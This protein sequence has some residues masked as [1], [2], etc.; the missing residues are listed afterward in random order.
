M[1]FDR[2]CSAYY[3]WLLL[4]ESYHRGA[5]L[6]AAT[7][8]QSGTTGAAARGSIDPARRGTGIAAANQPS[9]VPIGAG[10]HTAAILDTGPARQPGGREPGA[11][12]AAA[13]PDTGRQVA[14]H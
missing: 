14:C 2:V 11:G 1:P 12:C 6:G 9:A 10:A 4:R 8:C 5:S 13:D 3:P 7:G